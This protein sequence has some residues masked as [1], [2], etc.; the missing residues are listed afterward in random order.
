MWN[1]RQSPDRVGNNGHTPPNSHAPLP[2]IYFQVIFFINIH[3]NITHLVD[4]HINIKLSYNHVIISHLTMKWRVTPSPPLTR[5]LIGVD[6]DKSPCHSPALAGSDGAVIAI[7]VQLLGLFMCN[8]RYSR[9]SAMVKLITKSIII[10]AEDISLH[11]L[12]RSICS[13]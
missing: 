4:I 6:R 1:L 12:K 13:E 3:Y 5:P 7:G 8:L 2:Q 11:I 9:R 10:P